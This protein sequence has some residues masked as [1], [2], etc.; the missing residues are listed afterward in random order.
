MYAQRNNAGAL[1]NFH[2]ITWN[3]LRLPEK[4]H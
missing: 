2:L 4:V 1:A 3:F